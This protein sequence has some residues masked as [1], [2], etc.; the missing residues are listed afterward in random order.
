MSKRVYK[1]T[2]AQCAISNL[3]NNRLKLCPLDTTD[4][5]ISSAVDAVIAQFGKTASILCFSRNWDNL[6]TRQA[7]PPT[8]LVRG[9]HIGSS[10]AGRNMRIFGCL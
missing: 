2:S 3:Q 8:R 10:L 7:K 5:A 6:S 9:R 1:F 4:P